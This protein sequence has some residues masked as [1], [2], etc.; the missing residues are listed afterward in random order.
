MAREIVRYHVLEANGSELEMARIG[1]TLASDIS[2]EGVFLANANI[3]PGA[4][5][6]FYLDLPD[7]YIEV[8]G[9]AI[10]NQRRID[11]VGVARPGTGVRFLR[12]STHDRAR[13]ASYLA[14]RPASHRIPETPLR[15]SE[16]A[17]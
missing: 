15:R 16:T 3:A 11:P 13:L 9:K 4:H 17:V 5:V 12:V 8:V 10:H 7:G 6:H 2:Q 1:T 14:D